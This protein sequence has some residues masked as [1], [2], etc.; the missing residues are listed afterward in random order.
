M[1]QKL[2]DVLDTAWAQLTRLSSYVNEAEI[3]FHFNSARLP[4]QLNGVLEG[5]VH[6]TYS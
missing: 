6:V 3:G 4:L 2:R 5:K 1:P